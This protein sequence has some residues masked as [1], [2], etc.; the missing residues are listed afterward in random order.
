MKRVWKP[1]DCGG[2]R[3]YSVTLQYFSKEDGKQCYGNKEA[4]L[5]VMANSPRGAAG[6]VHKIY[7]SSESPIRIEC[8][9]H[10]TTV[11]MPESWWQEGIPCN[12][13]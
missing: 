7:N 4:P 2:K 9:G 10:A 1:L 3:L 11:L 5:L 8:Y 13:V 12:E 6:L